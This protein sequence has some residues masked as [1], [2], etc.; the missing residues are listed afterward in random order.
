MLLGEI[1]SFLLHLWY[2]EPAPPTGD[3]NHVRRTSSHGAPSSPISP[4]G[5]NPFK[6]DHQTSMSAKSPN[7]TIESKPIS[8]IPASPT[9]LSQS[10]RQSSIASSP[11][12]ETSPLN[13]L[14]GG[15]TAAAA[16]LKR[17]ATKLKPWLPAKKFTFKYSPAEYHSAFWSFVQCEHPDTTVLRFLRARRWNV[18]KAMEMLIL[19]LE[20]RITM[21]VDEILQESEDSIESKYPGFLEQLKSG[22]VI[23]RGR[24]RQ[25]R[26][27]C[28]IDPSKHHPH[29]QSQVSIEKLSIYVI[30]T[31][32]MMMLPPAE[33]ISIVF[34]MSNFSLS[35][36]D[37]PT[38]KFFIHAAEACYPELL[39]NCLVHRA[40]WMFGALWKVISPMIDPVIR[41]KIKF[42][43]NHRDLE[44]FIERDQLM[45]DKAYN[46]LDKAPYEF[47]PPAP[48]ENRLLEE[49]SEA[50]QRAIAK[51]KEL[52]LTFE[53]LT[54]IWQ[55][56]KQLSSNVA[57]MQERNDV[58]RRMAEEWWATAPYTRAKTLY[59][60]IGTVIPPSKASSE[61]K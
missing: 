29:A 38:T 18:E 24:D 35:N 49:D 8:S 25:G 44:E 40:P 43:H 17:S 32:R 2:A 42:T 33:T 9:R 13:S 57:V 41:A 4:K 53:R 11:P 23:F 22:K 27:L 31:A 48:G 26:P 56:Q 37:W 52:E 21:G 6:E 54:E 7:G 39:G 14:P 28:L 46:G 30:E 5:D 47:V 15:A 20:W 61:L 1:W 50:K 58:G 12:R 60:R 36:M 45:S 55:G 19:A 34:N 10:F 3:P 51:R 16:A 59:H